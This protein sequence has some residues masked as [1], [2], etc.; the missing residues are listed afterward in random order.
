M[1]H[2]LLD[3]PSVDEYA[4]CAAACGGALALRQGAHALAA[5][6]RR[7]ARA[8]STLCCGWMPSASITS[9]Q[10]LEQLLTLVDQALRQPGERPRDG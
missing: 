5:L 1:F 4:A 6:L 7:H 8:G 3:Y 2:V 9:R 10:S